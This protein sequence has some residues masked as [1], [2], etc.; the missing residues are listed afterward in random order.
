MERLTIHAAS[1]E[2]AHAMLAVLGTFSA[3]LVAREDGG[4]EVTVEL[5][6]DREIVDVL[7]ALEQY[8]SSRSEAARVELSGREYTMHPKPDGSASAGTQFAS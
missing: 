6:G 4:F 5:A 2:S 3:E 1:A 8:V 7:N